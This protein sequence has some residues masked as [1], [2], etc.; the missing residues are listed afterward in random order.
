MSIHRTS[1]VERGFVLLSSPRCGSTTL[2]ECLGLHPD[3]T[4]RSEPFNAETGVAA[5]VAREQQPAR[6]RAAFDRAVKELFARVDGIKHVLHQL[7]PL[8]TR[9]L[10]R[11]RRVI[12]LH[13]ANLLR[14]AVSN[15]LAFATGVWH[16]GDG[17]WPPK[18]L[19]RLDPR[20]LASTML[21]YERALRV[22]RAILTRDRVEHVELTYRELFSTAGWPA[23]RAM[24]DRLFDF[25]GVSRLSS[26]ALLDRA[27]AALDPTRHRLNSALTYRLIP[28]HRE[29]D[30]R[31]G[32]AEYGFLLDPPP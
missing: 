7:P 24:L 17:A 31:L 5:P 26:P 28:N 13:R 4:V 16:A 8:L 2:I 6:Q 23:Q 10:V 21:W 29:I 32:S 14:Q 3:L 25:I 27:R 15:T 19:P 30:E 20:E 9:R 18:A 11:A 22:H 1:A 12:L